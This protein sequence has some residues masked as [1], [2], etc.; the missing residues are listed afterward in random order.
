V[1]SQEPW[2]KPVIHAALLTGAWPVHGWTTLDKDILE[3]NTALVKKAIA[4]VNQEIA[5][6]NEVQA[7]YDRAKEH[8][9][10]TA[11]AA[12]GLGILATACIVFSNGLCAV[13][14]GAVAGVTVLLGNQ[15]QDAADELGDTYADLRKSVNDLIGG[16]GELVKTMH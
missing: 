5:K 2:L 1:A 9:T 3:A 11:V 16:L 8:Q 12:G 13:P 10:K 14:L 4:D 7:Q 6:I 15:L